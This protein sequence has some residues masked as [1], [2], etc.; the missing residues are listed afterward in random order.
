MKARASSLAE[1]RARR[2]RVVAFGWGIVW[3]ASMVPVVRAGVARGSNGGIWGTVSAIVSCACLFT[4]CSLSMRRIRQGLTWPSRLGLSLIIIGALTASGAALGVGSPGLQLVVFLAVVLAFSLPWQAAIGPIAILTGTLFLIPR[5]IP[6]WSA[7]EDAWIALLVAGG[8]CTFGRY[9]MEQRRVA[10]ILEQRTHELEINEERNRM[11]RDMHD[12][13]G[14]SLTV[15][16]LKSE[17]AAR[18]VDVAPDQ[19]RTELDEV[20]SLARSALADVRATVNSY[21]ELSL[22]GELARATSV[23]TSA[24]VRADLPLTVEVVDP[25]LRELFAWVVREGVTNI[26][27]HA[28]ASLCK[29]KLTTDSIEVA[30]DGIGLDSTGTGDGHGLEGLRQRCQDNGADL[31][32][33]APSSGSGT[34]LR[35]RARRLS[36]RMTHDATE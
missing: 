6:S 19:T 22:A 33:E 14:H 7:S 2:T 24:G 29:V 18:L 34:V 11:A 20:Q 32:I 8:A 1:A 23:L 21:R 31:T 27:R 9:I 4:A 3:A 17:L 5:M 26:V 10:R 35:V 16:A 30:D 36:S 28:H 25:E 12:I 15:I 13:L